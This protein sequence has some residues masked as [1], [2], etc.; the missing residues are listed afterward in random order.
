ML[1]Q[2]VRPGEVAGVW[3]VK[4]GRM[5]SIFRKSQCLEGRGGGVES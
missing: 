2:T 1:E 5:D 3:F 4:K